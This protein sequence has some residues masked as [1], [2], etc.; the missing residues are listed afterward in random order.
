MCSCCKGGNARACSTEADALRSGGSR[1][2]Q[3]GEGIAEHARI[4]L[5][6]GSIEIGSRDGLTAMRPP[7]V[8]INQSRCRRD[9]ILD[10]LRCQLLRQSDA[11]EECSI[12]PSMGL[13]TIEAHSGQAQL[14]AI[15]DAVH[16]P[17]RERRQEE[18]A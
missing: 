2:D 18:V 7:L 10:C 6:K 13:C 5:E 8:V 9:V 15:H 16:V 1:Q 3:M 17:V 12:S 11:G 4:A 14:E